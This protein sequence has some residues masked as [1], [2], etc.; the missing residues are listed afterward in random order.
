MFSVGLR[1]SAAR[2]HFQQLHDQIK[3]MINSTQTTQ[4]MLNHMQQKMTDVC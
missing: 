3:M 4:R 1:V 2:K